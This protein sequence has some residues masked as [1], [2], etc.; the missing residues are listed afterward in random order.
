VEWRFEQRIQNIVG[1]WPQAWDASRATSLGMTRDENFEQVILSY[2]N[3]LK[4]PLT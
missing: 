3:S 4:S 1:T 2:A